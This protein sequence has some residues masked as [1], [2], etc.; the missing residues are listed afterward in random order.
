[1]I[2][3]AIFSLVVGLF[4]S[5]LGLLPNV[6]TLPSQIYQAFA[7]V[8]STLAKAEVI[9]PVDSLFAAFGT[10]IA[11]EGAYFTFRLGVFVYNKIRG[12]G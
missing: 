8:G 4:S 7:F 5:L 10:V 2:T 3:T 11:F 1:M 12:S 6:S 9:F